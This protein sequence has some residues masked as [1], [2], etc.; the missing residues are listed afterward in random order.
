MDKKY[1]LKRIDQSGFKFESLLELRP[2]YG[3]SRTIKVNRTMMDFATE[4]KVSNC[5]AAIVYQ[6]DSALGESLHFRLRLNTIEQRNFFTLESLCSTP[7]RHNGLIS[8]KAFIE[9]GDICY[10]GNNTLKFPQSISKLP[11]DE[12]LITTKKPIITS[13]LPILI[14][15][16]TGTGKTTLA[17]KIHQ[18]SL[19]IGPFVHIN[20]SAFSKNLLESELFGH[21]KGAF[22][23]AIAVKKGALREAHNGTLFLDEIDSIDRETQTKLLLFLDDQKVRPVGGREES[24]NTRLI[25]SSGSSLTEMVKRGEMR[26]DFYFRISQGESIVLPKLRE[27]SDLI[28]YFITEFSI[29]EN[30]MFTQKL[31]DFYKTLPWPGNVRQLLGHLELKKISSRSRRIDF[32][33]IDQKLICLSSDLYDLEGENSEILSLKDMKEQYINQVYHK[34]DGHL[35]KTAQCLSIS[36]RVVRN[37]LRTA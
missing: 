26:K 9:Y 37:A 32:D 23:G 27:R 16:E 19:R 2:V 25:F 10:L 4:D 17:R 34:M 18:S 22:T 30:V 15:G 31:C 1:F 36:E 29:K 3:A 12:K 14:E 13:N 5:D 28:E 20:L 7:I 6:L 24:V 21:E 11:N 33:L 35:R 8:Y